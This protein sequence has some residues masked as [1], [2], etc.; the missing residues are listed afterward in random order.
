MPNNNPAHAIQASSEQPARLDHLLAR[1][2]RAN[3]DRTAIVKWSRRLSYA[4]LDRAVSRMANLLISRGVKAG[5]RVALSALNGPEFVVAYYGIMRAGAIVVPLNALIGGQL[6]TRRLRDCGAVMHICV[7]GPDGVPSADAAQ[8][9][10]RQVPSCRELIL[11]DPTETALDALLGE[12]PDTLDLVRSAPGDA[13]V[14]TYPKR[15]RGPV[16]GVLLTHAALMYGAAAIADLFRGDGG[17]PQVQLVALPL[18]HVVTQSLQLNAGIAVGATLV[19]KPRFDPDAALELIAAEKITTFVATPSMLWALASAAQQAPSQAEAARAC[20]RMVS[21]QLAPLPVAVRDTFEQQLGVL[22]LEGFGLSE[23]GMVALHARPGDREPGSVG[24]PLEGTQVRLVDSAGTEIAG[25]DTGI[26]QVRGPGLMAGYYQQPDTTES[27]MHDGWFHTGYY[28]RRSETGHYV[29]VDRPTHIIMRRGIAVYRRTVEEALLTHPAISSTKVV[30]TPDARNSEDVVTV[31][32]RDPKAVISEHEL[33]QWAYEQLPGLAGTRFELTQAPAGATRAEKTRLFAT[34]LLPGFAYA[35]AGTLL[36]FLI[37]WLVPVVSPLTAGVLL[38]V[39]AANIGI[40]TPRVTPGLSLSTKKLL[41]IGVVFLGLQL[42]LLEVLGLGG[43]L[44]LVVVAVVAFGYLFTVWVGR[45]L[46]LSEDLS[47]LTATGFSICGASAI[48]A[49]QGARDADDDEVA[50]AIALVTIFGT[51]AM[52]A[53]PFLQ[54]LLHLGNEAYGAWAGASVHEV[55]QV[56]A[57]AS[58]AGE[59]SLATAIVVKLARVIMLAPM[60]AIIAYAARRRSAADASAGG[61]RPPLIPLFVLGFLAMVVVRT[62]GV[63]PDEVL[64]GAKILTTIFLAAALF[65]LGVGVKVRILMATGP[66][67]LVLGAISTVSI[68]AVS[69]LGVLLAVGLT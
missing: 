54:G 14:M 23:T 2:A 11:I 49:M 67:A 13:A 30:A 32:E 27:V 12:Q 59:E 43:H 34:Q 55:A 4:E 64:A 51:V 52:F 62:T 20:L 31:I 25:P 57:A 66:R 10:A 38:G 46:G 6:L 22:P 28:A 44:L 50:M 7:V 1:T 58:P 33:L 19:M 35:A 39:V 24:T 8:N 42:S 68:A 29:M 16:S 26:L 41:R 9:A 15:T 40:V 3:A 61:K 47:L 69:Y 5:D 56:V 48:A 63:L 65:G 21:S 60:I 37:N 17:E 36:A 18:F 53:W 45:R